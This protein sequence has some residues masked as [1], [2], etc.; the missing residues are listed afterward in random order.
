MAY[1]S[2]PAFEEQS[3]FMET[4]LGEEHNLVS[5]ALIPFDLGGHLDLYYYPNCGHGTAVATKELTDW[6]EKSGPSNNCFKTYELVMFTRHAIAPAKDGPEQPE[7]EKAHSLINSILNLI[8]RYAPTATL[9]PYETLEFPAE[10]PEV[11][12]T[13][14]VF[15]AYPDMPKSPPIE[16]GLLGIM[17]IHRDEMNF[18][19][20]NGSEALFAMLK[21][22]GH[23]P[24]SDLDRPS[25][26]K[27][28][29]W[30]KFW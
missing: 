8:A 15:F 26:V 18:A 12:G 4:L 13:C 1:S 29:S 27:S 5:H 23:F 6:G 10:I 24:Y 7:L 2:I 20:K 9:N 30:W 21:E 11:G 17:A 22:K 14:T 3:R 19:R 16:F 25:V 28:K